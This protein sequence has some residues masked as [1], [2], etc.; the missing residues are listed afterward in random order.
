MSKTI[1]AVAEL[2]KIMQQEIDKIIIKRI[3][4]ICRIPKLRKYWIRKAKINA[5]KSKL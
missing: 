5:I 4:L 1:D 3:Y 2:N